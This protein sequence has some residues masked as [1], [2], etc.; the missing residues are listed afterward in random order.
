MKAGEQLSKRENR[1]I[2]ANDSGRDYGLVLAMSAR[3]RQASQAG[4]MWSLY[5]KSVA[6]S[7]MT[8]QQFQ[9]PAKRNKILAEY[10][11]DKIV[12]PHDSRPAKRRKRKPKANG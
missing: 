7:C 5:C 3:Q 12:T 1:H 4:K 11:L 10:G 8:F 6:K 2:E 9:K